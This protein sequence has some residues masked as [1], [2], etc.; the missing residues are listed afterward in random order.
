MAPQRID[1][2]ILNDA[3]RLAAL[4]RDHTIP[5]MA[6]LLGCSINTIRNRFAEFGI[7]ARNNGTSSHQTRKEKAQMA[8]R[9]A[10]T[11]FGPADQ[12]EILRPF[13]DELKEILTSAPAC[14]I[15]GGRD[16][17]HRP[18]CSMADKRQKTNDNGDNP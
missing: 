16:R 12:A 13:F 4:Y 11:A 17:Y 2:P 18:W 10:V 6:D 15:C 1:N 8:V 9:L 7:Q 14:P 5:E 3:Q